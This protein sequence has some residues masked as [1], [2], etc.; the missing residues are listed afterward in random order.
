MLPTTSAVRS[1]SFRVHGRTTAQQA[2]VP[3]APTGVVPDATQT[4]GRQRWRMS[5]VATGIDVALRDGESV[6]VRPAGIGDVP[7]LLAFLEGLS[8][9]AR[10][11]R[12]FGGGTDLAASARRLAAPAGGLALLATTG[13]DE[14]VVG[15]AMYVPIDARTA[16]A[17]F[18]V[19]GDWEGHGMAT[20]LLADLAEAAAA[21][22]I[23]HLTASVLAANHKMLEVI[24]QSG[25]TV[26][27]RAVA[28]ELELTFPTTLSAEGRRRFEERR[29]DAAV[30]AVTHVLRPSSVLVVG[31]S[32]RRGT[33]GGELLHN[34]VAGGY[35]GR[36]VAVNPRAREIQGVVTY[37][38]V[39]DVP[40]DIELAVITVPATAALTAARQCAAKG[41]RALLVISAGFGEAGDEGAALQRELLAICRAAGMRMVGPNCLGVVNT[42]PAVALD[43]TFSPGAPPAGRVGF[44]SQS[45]AF[46]IAAIDLARRR[47]IGLSSFVSLGD[48]ADLSGNDLL[49][50]WETDPATDVVMLYLESFGNPRRFAELARRLT[51]A[52][53]V[54]VV[55]GG[56]TAAGRRAAS[57]H[58]GALV[59]AADTSV[60]ALFRHAGVIR[61]ETVAELFDT[62]A[63]LSHEPLPAGSRV[64]VVTNVGGP[65]ILCADACEANGLDVAPLSDATRNT[66][67]RSLSAEASVS[68]PV[69]LIASATAEHFR[70]AMSAVLQDP[71]VDAVISVFVRP[72]STRADEVHRAV[73]A[74][75]AAHDGAAKPVLEVFLGDDTPQAPHFSGVEEAARA[76]AHAVAYADHRRARALP[77]TAPSGLD[78]DGAAAV[79]AGGLA[80]GAGWLA[81]DRVEAL[82]RSYG[83]PLAASR[84]VATPHA[85][86]RA[87]AQIGG[88]IA[89]KA[90]APGLVHKT[91]AGAVRL[92]LRTPAAAARAAH[93]LRDRLSALGVT[94]T[95]FLVQAM[96]PAG[97]ELLVGVVGD[98]DFGPLVAV[99]AGGT[100]AELIGDVQ[101]RL[102]PVG[103]EEAAGMVGALRC[104][105]LL[106]GFRG[107]PKA[108]VAA[109]ADV[110]A[111]VSAL[112]AAHP[113]IAELDCNPLIAGQDGAVVVDAR[114]RLEPAP[115]PRPYGALDR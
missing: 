89:V 54:L 77:D 8:E 87:A 85:V 62:A 100:A 103:L 53:P 75:A 101:V 10:Y 115:E 45:G 4:R 30:A 72:L 39:A 81:A 22:G 104:F 114:V 68:N 32:R 52:K 7:R 111:R 80:D 46:G 98:R 97:P 94:V 35:T 64:A 31:A 88:S 67:R 58:T 92:G 23:E 110:V 2:G 63:V 113:Q 90:V 21:D 17:A 37:P 50:F 105:P 60:D 95:A 73:C 33:V 49:Q 91:D 25:F 55:K 93:E 48:K 69:D 51:P 34:L 27:V 38:S 76:L 36:L 16:E 20:T 19:A 79:V 57:S 70:D 3:T 24:R 1:A 43:A 42:D 40:G 5:F 15:H 106:E 108:D 112:A 109:V 102:A 82:L 71:G 11:F 26:E 59:A 12:F 84:T 65:G 14:R 13:A 66:L 96:A 107:A 74:A 29:R 78:P 99:G 56:R 44:A 83:V 28:G 6:H 86:R 18:A 9:E 47:G 41:V 61:C